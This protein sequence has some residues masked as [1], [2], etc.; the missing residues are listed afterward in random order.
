M[1]LLFRGVLGQWRPGTP[2]LPLVGKAFGR[3]LVAA[4]DERRISAAQQRGK[5]GV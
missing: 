4:W 1:N 3:I 5:F 2:F